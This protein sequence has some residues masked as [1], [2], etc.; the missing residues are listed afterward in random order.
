M[1]DA[2]E[3]K[4]GGLTLRMDRT[5]CAAFKDCLGIAPEAFS[6]GEDD[7]VTFL[8]PEQVDRER[9]IDA[10][11]VCPANALIILDEEGK[12]IVP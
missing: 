5:S 2:C 8:E 3:R 9:L 10:C 7:I 1:S 12:Q 6:L 4:V 11:T